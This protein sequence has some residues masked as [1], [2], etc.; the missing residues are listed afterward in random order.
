MEEL[1]LLSCISAEYHEALSD[2]RIKQS[3]YGL[4]SKEY[5]AVAYYEM[6]AAE[7]RV[8]AIIRSI[9]RGGGASN[10]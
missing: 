10:D 7:E 2:L 4:V 8:N 3:N 9:Q 6:K 1:T 5:E